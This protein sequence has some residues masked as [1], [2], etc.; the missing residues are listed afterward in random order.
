M[1][2]NETTDDNDLKHV[3]Q[4]STKHQITLSVNMYTY[5]YHIHNSMP[6]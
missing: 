1:N 6:K 2:Q 5:M 3:T 4:T